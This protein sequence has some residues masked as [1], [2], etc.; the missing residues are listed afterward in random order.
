MLCWYLNATYEKNTVRVWQRGNDFCTWHWYVIEKKH[1][2]GGEAI[3]EEGV[4]IIDLFYSMGDE[5][6]N[7][8]RKFNERKDHIVT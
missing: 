6:V 8:N 1:I 5:D 4:N 3:R 2:L 7:I